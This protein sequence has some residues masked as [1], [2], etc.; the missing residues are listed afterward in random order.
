M[1]TLT[2]AEGDVGPPRHAEVVPA[3]VAA[4]IRAPLDGWAGPIH[5]SELVR[6]ARKGDLTETERANLR[7]V[8]VKRTR[9]RAEHFWSQPTGVRLV[10]GWQTRFADRDRKRLERLPLTEERPLEVWTLREVKEHLFLPLER[11]LELLARLEAMYWQP[12]SPA[13]RIAPTELMEQTA[14]V[15]VTPELQ[16]LADAVLELPWLKGVSSHDLRF[17]HG[18][19]A[20]LPDWI[21]TQVQGSTVPESFLKLL[22]RLL[23][24]EQLTAAE[25]AKDI[26]VAAARDCAPKGAD[27]AAIERWVSIF[28]RRHISPTGPGRILADVGAEFGVTRERI[29]QICESF[30]EYL[31][32]VQ[33]ATPALDRALRAAAR[34]APAQV[35]DLDEQLRRFIGDD[36]GMASLVPW[37][38]VL[39]RDKLPIR[40]QKTR[41]SVRGKF[42]EVVMVHAADEADW[43]Q[44]MIRH[45]SR[46]SSMFGCTNLLR[47]AGRL[48]LKEGVAPGQEAI[49]A[50]L[51]STDG[52][53]WLDEETGWFSLGDSSTSSVALR[54]RKILAIAHD[55][56]GTDEIAGALASDDMMLYREEST[57]GLATPPVHVLRELFKGWPWLEV[58]QRGRYRPGPGFDPTGALSGVEQA[59]VDVITAHDGV[60]CR[61]EL[62]EVVIGKLGMTDVLLAHVLGSSPIVERIEHGLYKLRGRR[63]GD[64]A[65]GAAR[66]RMRE[67]FTRG[68]VDTDANQFS[69]KVTEATMRNEQYTVPSLFKAKLAGKHHR[70]FSADGTE[71]GFGRVGQA[72]SLAGVNRYFPAVRAGDQYVI[73]LRDD[74][75]VVEHVSHAESPR[76]SP[77]P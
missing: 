56:I 17:G 5:P 74:G 63:I 22:E 43:V 6:W 62:K 65:L 21:R 53:R 72:G 19:D 20:P 16:Q 33:P 70:L 2:R 61:I 27:T 57:L 75:L 29:R 31:A 37:A 64:G 11:T 41:T 67:R 3:F 49:S 42:L 13:S 50:A 30:E 46:D 47:V 58:V 60:A 8:I 44:A 68:L 10:K 38:A 4:S 28:L 40:C 69:V 48:A 55:S 36:A 76:S 32:E 24:A 39:G 73:A 15:A 66:R 26:A 59:L 54:V 51:V 34:V 18:A 35:D 52:F 1:K 23:A 12:P 7:K 77:P 25:E 71:L 9:V 45:V 14:P